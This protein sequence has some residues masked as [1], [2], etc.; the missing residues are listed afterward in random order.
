M[1][2]EDRL[3][4]VG[5]THARTQRRFYTLSNAMHSIA[6]DRQ[7]TLIPNVQQQYYLQI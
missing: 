6:L 2:K 4:N 7:K 1:W 5:R 3:R